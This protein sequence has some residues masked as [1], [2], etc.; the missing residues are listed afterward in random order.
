MPRKILTVF[1]GIVVSAS[2]LG[3][4]GCSGSKEPAAGKTEPAK[5]A[6]PQLETWPLTGLPREDKTSRPAVAV[7]VENVAQARPQSG[8]ENA[9][10]VFEELVEGGLTRFN[11]VFH[12]NQPTEIGPVRSVRPTDIGIVKP[13]DALLVYSGGNP[14]VENRV[15]AEGIRGFN[16]DQAAGAAYRVNFNYMPHNLYLSIPDLLKN[17]DTAGAAEPGEYFDFVR[18]C[19]EGEKAGAAGSAGTAGAA[20]AA[21]TVGT[22]GGAAGTGVGGAT[23]TQTSTGAKTV[24]DTKKTKGKGDKDSG[25]SD[26]DACE[27]ST[28]VSLGVAATQLNIPFPAAQVSFAWDGTKWL[29]SDDGVP[30]GSRTGWVLSATNVVVIETTAAATGMVDV[31]GAPV[32]DTVLQGSGRAWVAS[33]GKVLECT[34]SKDS[35]AAPLSLTTAAGAP[36]TLT[37]GQ[38][39]V[40]LMTSPGFSYN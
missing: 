36:V 14:L 3:A 10:I 34:W 30:S 7:K 11:A 17:T 40:E 31:V 13:F 21:G 38:T 22:S 5:T 25:E 4:T 32:M 15:A 33:G 9:D 2:L 19:P 29:R 8:L 35:D 39:W 20:G 12:S 1:A 6:A 23:L 27:W 16:E 26:T 18:G 24:A 37:P 28:A